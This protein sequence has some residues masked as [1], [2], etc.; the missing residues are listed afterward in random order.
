MTDHIAPTRADGLRPGLLP[1]ASRVAKR[2]L[3]ALLKRAERRRQLVAL[4]ALDNRLRDDIG[5]PPRPDAGLPRP[6]R[7]AAWL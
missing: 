4:E 7:N 1:P 3:G 5:L 6:P 2:L